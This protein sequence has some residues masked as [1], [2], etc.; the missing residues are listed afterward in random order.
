M[1]RFRLPKLFAATIRNLLRLR[2]DCHGNVAVMMGLLIVPITGTLGLG[3][4]ISN[5]YMGKR[6]MQNA[7]DAAAIAAASNGSSNYD[8]EAKA[9]TALYGYVDGQNNV[10]VTAS[11][12][13]TCPTGGN[14]CYS[15]TIS[16]LDPLFLSQVV[17]YNGDTT[18]NGAK[19]TTIIS[20][21][22]AQQ[23]TVQQPI[24][25]LA[26]GTTGTALRTNGAP[27]SNF[28]GCTVMS[29]SAANCNGS[30]LD[31]NYGLATGS[32]SGCGNKEYSNIPIVQDPYAHMAANLPQNNCASYPQEPTNKKSSLPSTNQLNGTL[33]VT[34]SLTGAVSGMTYTGKMFCGDIQLTGNVVINTPSGGGTIVIENGQLDLNGFT[35]STADGSAVTVVFSG[36]NGGYTHTPTDNSTGQGGVL[37]IQAPSGGPF[38]GIAIYQDPT[39]NTGVDLTYKGNNPTWDITGGVYLPNS[40]VQVSGD[41]SQSS[42]GADCFVMIANNILINGT[43]NIYQQSPGGAGCKQAGLNMPTATIPG[44]GAL[45]Y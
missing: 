9:V 44:R 35:L 22:I 14:N 34:G 33:S 12:T 43:S 41:V 8:I 20:M 24:C 38:P 3:F 26:L 13:A 28:S 40:S 5:W 4:E 16:R 29:D 45:V 17:G 7:A 31:A 32:N 18:V 27:N 37:N 39:L 11:N 19:Q 25:L 21:A 36:S 2:G 30:N 1:N 23:A 15:V 42:F 6:A 10:T